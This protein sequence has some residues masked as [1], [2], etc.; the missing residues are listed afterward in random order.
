MLESCVVFGKANVFWCQ[1]SGFT[2]KSVK[3]GLGERAGDFPCAVGAEVEEYNAVA[4]F[5]KP[6]G[7]AVFINVY[8]NDKLVGNAGGVTV[9]NGFNG[10]FGFKLFLFF[11][12]DYPCP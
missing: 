3:I 2:N 7:F 4:L 1:I 5:D 6:Y 10:A 11:P 8:G 12:N 9:F